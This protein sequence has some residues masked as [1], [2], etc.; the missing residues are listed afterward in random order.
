MKS[1][2]YILIEPN[3]GFIPNTELNKKAGISYQFRRS[4][5]RQFIFE[6]MPLSIERLIV[7]EDEKF[8]TKEKMEI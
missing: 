5:Y 7:K 1:L 6:N 3:I 8:G 4:H 2:K